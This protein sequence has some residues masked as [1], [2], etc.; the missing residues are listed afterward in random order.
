MTWSRVAFALLTA[1]ALAGTPGLALAADYHHVHITTSSPARGIEWYSNHLGCEPLA[2]R[3]DAAKCHGVELVFVPQPTAGGTQG[4]G[5]N[6]IGFSYADL[7]AKMAELEAVGVAGTGVSIGCAPLQVSRRFD[8]VRD[9]P[10]AAVSRRFDPV[11]SPA[12]S[13]SASSSIHGAPGSSSSKIPIGSAFTTST[14]APPTPT[15]RSPGI[16]TCWV[17]SGRA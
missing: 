4:T 16:A 8:R 9:I 2:D 7:T 11:T 5:V 1:V 13:R 3:D 17:A 12:C 6:H 14:S 15:P 10:P